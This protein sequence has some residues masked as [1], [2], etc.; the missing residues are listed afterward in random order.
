MRYKRFKMNM[1]DVMNDAMDFD[2]DMFT[3]DDPSDSE[4]SRD[5][6]G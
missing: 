4:Y 3:E 6:V 5:R 1:K 2:F